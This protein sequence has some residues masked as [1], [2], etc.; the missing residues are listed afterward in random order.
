[1]EYRLEVKMIALSQVLDDRGTRSFF[2][3]FTD[4][5]GHIR[6][7]LRSAKVLENPTKLKFAF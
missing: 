3:T 6:P 2:I 4:L 1:M 7:D 5:Q